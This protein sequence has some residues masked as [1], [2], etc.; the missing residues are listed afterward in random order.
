MT[1]RP[2]ISPTLEEALARLLRTLTG[3]N[4]SHATITA[5]RTDASQFVAFLR[6]TSCTVGAPAHVAQ[7]LP[8]TS[9]TRLTGR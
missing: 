5:D 1:T 9:A 4:T 8:S 2:T 3:S 7:T 6:E